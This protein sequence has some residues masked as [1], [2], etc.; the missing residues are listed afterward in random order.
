MN[1]A[2]ILIVTDTF[3]VGTGIRRDTV[4]AAAIYRGTDEITKTVARRILG[5][6]HV[7]GWA[8]IKRIEEEAKKHGREVTIESLAEREARAK[9][10]QDLAANDDPRK[11]VAKFRGHLEVLFMEEPPKREPNR[12]ERKMIGFGGK[13]FRVTRDGETRV[14]NL[15]SSGPVPQGFIGMFPA[16]AVV[17]D[18]DF[19]EEREYYAQRAAK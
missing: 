5:K 16:T 11:I 7:E 18:L 4:V 12:L 13:L 6:D 2:P 15:W 9:R 1:R 10:W 19:I 8:E 3:N 17:E 14:V